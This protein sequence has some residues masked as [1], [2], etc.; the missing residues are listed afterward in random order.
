MSGFTTAAIIE[1]W[2]KKLGFDS[3]HDKAFYEALATI[4]I[5]PGTYTKN[6]P[7]DSE[8]GK[9]NLL[10]VLYMCEH[11]SEMFAEKGISEEILMDTLAEVTHNCDI[12]SEIHGQLYL[13]NLGWLYNIFDFYLFRL[14]RLNFCVHYADNRFVKFGMQPGDLFLGIHIPSGEPLKIDDCKASIAMAREFYAKYFPERDYKCFSC[15]SWLLDDTLKELLHEGSNI[16]KFS[17][18]F[19]KVASEPSDDILEF[20]FRHDATRENIDNF[21]CNSSLAKKVKE[22]IK[23]GRVFYNTRGLIE[24]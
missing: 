23:A 14:G 15:N 13:G 19:T 22:Y 2:Y 20:V 10:A 16:L 17:E 9:K 21:P 18:L 7:Y 6:Y 24:K 8:D 5:A 11:L 3:K 4:E 12:W 1:K